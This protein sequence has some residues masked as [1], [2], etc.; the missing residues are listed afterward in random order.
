[1][2]G[3]PPAQIATCFAQSGSRVFS[4]MVFPLRPGFHTPPT[5]NPQLFP[6]KTSARG[7]KADGWTVTIWPLARCFLLHIRISSHHV[8]SSNQNIIMSYQH[9]TIPYHHISTSSYRI[10]MSDHHV[11]VSDHHAITSYHIIRS[12]DQIFSQSQVD[13]GRHVHKSGPQKSS[14]WTRIGSRWLRLGPN[15]VKMTPRTSG[16]FSKPSWA[17]KPK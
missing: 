5:S 9:I 13:I 16:S 15:F 12:A 2:I 17:Q 7:R 11:I 10:I 6:K 4:W 1:M 14:K 8:V 3:G